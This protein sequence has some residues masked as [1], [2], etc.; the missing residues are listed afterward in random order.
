MSYILDAL[1][2]SAKD[3][4]RGNLPDMLTV[5]DIVVEKPR[6][7]LPWPFLLIAA[8]LLNAGL[9]VWWLAFSHTEKTK[10]DHT[11]N[12]PVSLSAE[13]EPEGVPHGANQ[14]PEFSPPI[15]S[16]LKTV[17][18][19]SVPLLEDKPSDTSAKDPLRVKGAKEVTG[20]ERKIASHRPIAVN[21]T[22]VPPE[23]RPAKPK[24]AEGINR[25]STEAAGALPE[26]LDENKIY[27]LSELPSSVRQN[28]PAFSISALLYS[29]DPASRMVSINGQMMYEGQDFG[30]L[31]V[32][33]IT[34]VGVIFR[35]QK[36]R[37]RVD[38]K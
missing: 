4:Q 27:R 10:D 26:V 34:R 15:R 12:A 11:A 28:L 9:L 21:D 6:K 8:L 5:Q 36:I 23:S 33:E 37:F 32:E 18:K 14:A 31:K 20:A 16:E 30:G 22:R 1:K 2:K 35:N 19:T 3:R 13:E 24:Q 17:E 7:R 38:L 25:P 29:S